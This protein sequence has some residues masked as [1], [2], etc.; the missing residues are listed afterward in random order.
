MARWTGV[1]LGP[2]S[3]LLL[4]RTEL[5]HELAPRELSRGDEL[6]L[7]KTLGSQRE[8]VLMADGSREAGAPMQPLAHLRKVGNGRARRSELVG[9]GDASAGGTLARWRV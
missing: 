5:A 3:V 1:V 4:Q 6:A 8:G 2:P 9:S 7:V